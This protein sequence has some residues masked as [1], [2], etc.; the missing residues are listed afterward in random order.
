MPFTSHW[1]SGGRERGNRLWKYRSGLRL[2]R[3][4][5]QGFV[6]LRGETQEHKTLQSPEI[7]TDLLQQQRI[8]KAT[9]KTVKQRHSW[10][11]IPY[12]SRW[13]G[14]DNV[15]ALKNYC[16]ISQVSAESPKLSS[17]LFS[18]SVIDRSHSSWGRRRHRRTLQLLFLT[19][20]RALI[21]ANAQHESWLVGLHRAVIKQLLTHRECWQSLWVTKRP[22]KTTTTSDLCQ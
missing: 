5:L 13:R 8:F 3:L 9:D 15:T 7:F 19:C 4:W 1:H 2:N 11:I 17:N 20:C 12:V 16:N 18:S 6:T 14:R 22:G 21:T 10:D